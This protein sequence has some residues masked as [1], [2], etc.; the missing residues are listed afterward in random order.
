MLFFVVVVVCFF[1]RGADEHIRSV[2]TV[3]HKK[4]LHRTA[5]QRLKAALNTFKE[6]AVKFTELSCREHSIDAHH[7][8]AQC[9]RSVGHGQ[10]CALCYF[11]L[12]NII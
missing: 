4:K 5:V 9:L 2:S 8:Q 1:L 12:Q 3:E 11:V 7:K 6:C 10:V